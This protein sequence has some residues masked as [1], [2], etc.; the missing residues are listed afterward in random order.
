MMQVKMMMIA[1]D[2]G[3]DGWNEK[4]SLLLAVSN[5]YGINPESPESS[6]RKSGSS[7]NT[8]SHGERWG[9]VMI[10]SRSSANRKGAA[11]E[12]NREA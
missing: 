3:G 2:Q 5:E 9:K 10:S 12:E 8:V 1:L 7:T 6:I 4:Q 11:F